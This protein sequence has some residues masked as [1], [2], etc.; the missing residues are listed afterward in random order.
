MTALPDWCD[1]LPGAE[2]M[3]AA[4]R[5]AIEERGIA[6]LTLMERAG[7]GLALLVDRTVPRGPVAIVC[8][9]GN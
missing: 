6:S 3:R 9:K 4:D 5:W 2:A 7:A 1:A 8:G